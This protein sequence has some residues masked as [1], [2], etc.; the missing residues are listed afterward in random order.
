MPYAGRTVALGTRH[1]K[2]RAFAPPLLRRLGLSVT[3]ADLDT[4]RLGTFSG[5]VERVAS[6]RD[7]VVTKARL[8]AEA[9][10]LP[11]GLASEGSFGPH[12]SLPWLAM[13]HE[14]ACFLDLE[15][16]LALVESR[17][18]L[19]TNFGHATGRTPAEVA[20]FL[21]RARFPGH[22]IIARPNA[23]PLHPLS[24]GVRDLPSLDA[25]M[26]AAAA[27]SPDGLARVETDMRAHLNPTRLGEIRKVA[28]RLARRLATPCPACASPGFGPD[29]VVPG[30]PCG[31]CGEPTPAPLGL[32]WGCPACGHAELRPLPRQPA[33]ADPG[34]CPGCNP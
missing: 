10:G 30:L 12:P 22:A 18:S 3:V 24:K 14:L 17:A 9:A 4:D 6:P 7:T 31:W 11:L 33:L 1:G 26:A 2:E 20:G 28:A 23:G 13:G 5:E 25:A 32:S 15:R 19:R 16:G 21:A 27:A 29:R 34:Q 8:A